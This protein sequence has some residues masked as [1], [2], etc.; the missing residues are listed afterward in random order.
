MLNHF[1]RTCLLGSLAL[2]MGAG[3]M[4]QTPPWPSKPVKFINSFPPGGPSDILAMNSI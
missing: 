4:A 1:R 3:T 2:L